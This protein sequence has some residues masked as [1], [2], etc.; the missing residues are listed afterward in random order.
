M[1]IAQSPKRGTEQNFISLW[2]DKPLSTIMA[3][4]GE[5]QPNGMNRF[6]MMTILFSSNWKVQD[7]HF[8]IIEPTICIAPLLYHNIAGLVLNNTFRASQMYKN[9]E[10][11][12][13]EAM[14]GNCDKMTGP[15]VVPGHRVSYGEPS[16]K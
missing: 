12:K 14:H 15:K 8:V 2:G 3:Y 4:H 6:Y 11:T 7:I 5:I 13:N 9:L 16:V 10:C 1:D